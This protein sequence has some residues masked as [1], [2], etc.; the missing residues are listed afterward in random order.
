MEHLDPLD[1]KIRKMGDF[2]VCLEI[3]GCFIHVVWKNVSL[4]MG[5]LSFQAT[6]T[7]LHSLKLTRPLKVG[8][9][10]RKFIFQPLMFKGKLLVSGRV[11]VRALTYVP[12]VGLDLN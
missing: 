6:E 5:N 9:P 2:G 11:L 4:K 7:R 10:K 12:M 1:S 8:Y 3:W